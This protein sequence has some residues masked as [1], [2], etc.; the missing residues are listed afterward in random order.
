MD[1]ELTD[2]PSF[3]KIANNEDGEFME[4]PMESDG[5]LLVSTLQSQFPSGIGLKYKSSS[6]GWRGIRAADEKLDPPFGG[7]G[8]VI[9][10][11]TESETS[12][13][14]T[15]GSNDRKSR[16]STKLLEDLIVLG[17][18]FATTEE[19]FKIYFNDTCGE[20][21][22]CELK[23]DRD[24]KKSRGFGFIRF[25]TEEGAEAAL[26]GHHELLGRK[27]EIRIS[28][29]KDD[30]AMKL[31]IG[32]L[33]SGT[34]QEDVNDYFCDYGEL[35]DVFVPQN[36]F[37]GFG[38]ITFASQDDGQKV[39]RMN[40]MIKGARLNVTAAEPKDGDGRQGKFSGGRNNRNGPSTNHEANM[41]ARNAS[42]G[43]T[44]GGNSQFSGGNNARNGGFDAHN[45]F[46][47]QQ[48]QVPQAQQND[49]A[50]Q[51]KDMLI[52]LI[53]TQQ[54]QK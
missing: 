2:Y 50:N 47:S 29:K 10:I 54:Q 34:T 6:G 36:P 4:L 5:S 14:K 7:W 46:P 41:G 17:L 40:H 45:Q 13:R 27:L 24:T 25:K 19:E 49:V 26:K 15:C 22:Y 38:F 3:V 51:L 44:N 8:E 43:S 1:D 23:V 42:F 20:L 12:K 18:P 9:Y 37:R 31:F 11:V 21:S 39:L 33:A 48:Q 30:V 28:R 16:K 35:I 32:R 52:T 53:N